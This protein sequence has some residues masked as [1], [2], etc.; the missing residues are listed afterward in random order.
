MKLYLLV[1][2]FIIQAH[3]IITSD[4]TDQEKQLI[5]QIDVRK[6]KLQAYWPE[7][8]STFPNRN[9][10]WI[11]KHVCLHRQTE[12][13]YAGTFFTFKGALSSLLFIAF[14][15][16]QQEYQ[17]LLTDSNLDLNDHLYHAIKYCPDLVGPLLQRGANANYQDTFTLVEL[18]FLKSNTDEISTPRTRRR[19]FLTTLQLLLQHNAN[20]NEP[21]PR[22]QNATPIFQ[23]KDKETLQLLIRHGARI[24][25]QNQSGWTALHY[26]ALHK[27]ESLMRS[28]LHFGADPKIKATDGRTACDLDPRVT[29]LAEQNQRTNT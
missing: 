15:E 18:T 14:Q 10:Y 25:E 2:M 28:L 13:G 17:R 11:A 26:A 20:P 9:T 12:E 29:E 6:T 5:A 3:S 16:D 7:L 21:D 19:T 24:N 22:N 27:N 4:I 23:A 1:T 8:T